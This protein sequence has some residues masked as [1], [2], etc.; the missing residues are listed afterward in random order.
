M[1]IGLSWAISAWAYVW[2][3]KSLSSCGMARLG[4]VGFVAFVLIPLRAIELLSP[5]LMI[6]AR[7]HHQC[8]PADPGRLM[9]IRNANLSLVTFHALHVIT[10]LVM[11]TMCLRDGCSEW[12]TTSDD[13]QCCMHA[14]SSCLLGST[15]LRY[16]SSLAV[17]LSSLCWGR[18]SSTLRRVKFGQFWSIAW[19]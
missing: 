12:L 9:W 17:S 3:L 1:W 19:V 8:I 10:E 14:M 16:L 2:L 5:A 7:L 6:H 4:L 15:N 11:E 13:H 18:P